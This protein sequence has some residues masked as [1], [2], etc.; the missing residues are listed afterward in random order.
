MQEVHVG[1]GRRWIWINDRSLVSHRG[2]EE[3]QENIGGERGG[4]VGQKQNQKKEN[5]RR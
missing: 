3:N 4:G 2:W 1:T 5:R